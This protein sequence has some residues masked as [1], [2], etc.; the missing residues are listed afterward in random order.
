MSIT[1]T[2]FA[3][4]GAGVLGRLR[5]DSLFDRMPAALGVSR[6]ARL[7]PRALPL[8]P[9]SSERSGSSHGSLPMRLLSS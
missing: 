4:T 7:G 9:S 3:D 1:D 5:A 8:S 2:D 6:H